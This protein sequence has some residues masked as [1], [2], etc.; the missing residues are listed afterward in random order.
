MIFNTKTGW[1]YRY[2]LTG[3]CMIVQRIN[4]GGSNTI[5]H[6]FYLN[7]TDGLHIHQFSELVWVLDGEITITTDGKAEIGRQ[8]D[9]F[10][11]TP[12]RPHEFNTRE[13]SK[14]L[15]VCFSNDYAVDLI[16]ENKWYSERESYKFHLS[17]A[18]EGYLKEYFARSIDD[19]CMRSNDSTAQVRACIHTIL[20]DFTKYVPLSRSGKS[21][22]L[23][24]ILVYLANHFKEKITLDDLSRALGYSKGYISHCLESIPNYNFNSLLNSLRIE[25]AKTLLAT[26]EMRAIDIALESGFSCERSFHRAFKAYTKMTPKEYSAKSKQSPEE[27]SEHRFQESSEE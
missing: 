20:A 18:L 3:G 8:G 26:T 6:N 23:S 19:F 21:N 13:Y 17:E 14:I 24:S 25:Y 5:N 9:M 16:P 2:N 1:F 10:V 12:Y 27:L 7:H 15:I 11:I 4:F 22:I